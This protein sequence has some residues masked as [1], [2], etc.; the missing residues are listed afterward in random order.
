M[1]RWNWRGIL[2]AIISLLKNNYMKTNFLKCLL[3]LL[4]IQCY[5]QRDIGVGEFPV[6]SLTKLEKQADKLWESGEYSQAE[7]LYYQAY[8]SKTDY[9]NPLIILARNKFKICDVKGANAIYD[10]ILNHNYNKNLQIKKLLLS[11]Y[12]YKIPDATQL[13]MFMYYE[14]LDKNF[15]RGDTKEAIATSIRWINSLG[16]K[17][18]LSEKG[19]LSYVTYNAS[20]AAFAIGDKESLVKLHDI[21]SNIKII[22]F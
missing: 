5:S 15:K 9:M 17:I 4:A 12:S 7:K 13:T 19:T 18:G 11:A 3:L 22:M 14:K 16:E 20:V 1:E 2:G 10:S 6:G 8:K 21:F